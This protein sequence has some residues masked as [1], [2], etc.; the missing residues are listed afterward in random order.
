MGQVDHAVGDDD[1][2]RGVRQGDVLDVP[3]QEGGVRD[4][5][6]GLVAAGQ[7]KGA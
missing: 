3:L 5:G 2:D 4:A 1:V 7:I 6:L